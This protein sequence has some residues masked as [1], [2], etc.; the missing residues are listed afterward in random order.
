[1]P[2]PTMKTPI[3]R[4]QRRASKAKTNWSFPRMRTNIGTRRRRVALLPSPF[5]RVPFHPQVSTAYCVLT[6]RHSF[7]RV[8]VDFSA[9]TSIAYA[10]TFFRTHSSLA[11]N[12]TFLQRH[13]STRAHIWRPARYFVRTWTSSCTSVS[14][15]RAR[16]RRRPCAC[17]ST[18]RFAN[19]T[20]SRARQR[21]CRPATIARIIAARCAVTTRP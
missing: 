17:R 12:F 18:R 16:A 19:S 4:A 5:L 3:A 14:P 11:C 7:H 10:F 6:P 2:T 15:I 8:V 13:T 21:A 1:M 20:A 9:R